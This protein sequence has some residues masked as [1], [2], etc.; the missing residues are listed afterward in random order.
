MFVMSHKMW[1]AHYGMDPGVVGRTFVL[2]GISTTCVGVMPQRFTK[3]GADL[4]KPIRLDRADPQM[5]SRYFVFQ[6]KLKPGM[7][8]E[9]ATVEMDVVARRIAKLYPDN[10]P[11]QFTV[12]VVSWVDGLVRQFRSTLYTLLGAVGVLLLI[13]CG[14]VAN[15]L[16]ARAAARDKEMAVRTSLGASRWLLIRQLLVE[17]LMLA[18]AGGVLGCAF[19]T[20]ACKV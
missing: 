14:N 7:T 17:S 16:L 3:Q 2:N 15:M 19:G 1:V 9:R 8:L 20:S 6:A 4:W 13:A 12:H 10:Y 18:M 11:P 5:K